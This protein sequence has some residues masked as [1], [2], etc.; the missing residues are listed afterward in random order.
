MLKMGQNWAKI[1]NY[2]PNAQ[3]RFS[4]LLSGTAGHILPTHF[5]GKCAY[6]TLLNPLSKSILLKRS[7]AQ[8]I[9]RFARLVLITL[10]YCFNLL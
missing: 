6:G 4:P 7:A 9:S 5:L 8:E 2:P 1:A 10:T 3:Q